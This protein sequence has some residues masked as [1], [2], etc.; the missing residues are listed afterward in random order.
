MYDASDPDWTLVGLSGEYGFAPANYIEVS[1]TAAPATPSRPRIAVPGPTLQEPP[2]PSS[3]GS[4]VQSPAAA[5]AGIIAQKTGGPAANPARA[6]A[7]PPLPARQPQPQYTPEE[8]E[9]EQSAPILPQRPLS[10][11]VSPTPVQYAS[12][13]SPEPFGVLASPPHNRVIHRDGDL[14]DDQA[15]KSPGGFHLYNIHE[16]VSHMGKNKKMPMTLGINVG[17]GLI[18]ISPEKSRDGPQKEWTA[19][20]LTHYSIEGKHVFM[21]LV[22]PS[23][24]IDF[25]AGAKDTAQEIVRAL[26]ELAGAARAEGLREVI[27]ASSGSGG[28]QKK[29]QMLYEFMAQGE[30]EVT[31]AVGDEVI[32][33]DD[34][35]SDEWWLVRRLKNGKEG[36]VPSSYV[37]IT[38]TIPSTSQSSSALDAARSTVEQN[39]LEE[40]RMARE[41]SRTHRK[42][43]ESEPKGA[44]VGP[45]LQLP[46]RNSSLQRDNDTERSSQRGKRDSREAKTPST[47]KPSEC[48]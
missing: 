46:A 7:S 38:G 33:V 14:D 20:K 22:R 41:A 42:R 16:M 26:G 18:M 12:P 48:D 24:S 34:A 32:V 43:E 27:A 15:L 2:T 40:Q 21:E 23:R 19:D 13:R 44:E 17:K 36:M 25:H 29:G 28:G 4:P 30:D 10:G 3:A 35:K 37:E 31:V 6:L 47:S 1:E 39:R 5:L 11:A 8:S 9:E 45:G